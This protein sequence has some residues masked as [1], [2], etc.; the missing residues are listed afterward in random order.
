MFQ[1]RY[2]DTLFTEQEVNIFVIFKH[3]IGTATE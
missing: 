1:L 3:L 2:T